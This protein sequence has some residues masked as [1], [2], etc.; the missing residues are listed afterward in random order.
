MSIKQKMCRVNINLSQ[1][2][3]RLPNH[4]TLLT[5][6]Q[7][8]KFGKIAEFKCREVYAPQNREKNVS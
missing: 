7:N 4:F 5:M 8:T 1:F 3:Y 2:V 6:I